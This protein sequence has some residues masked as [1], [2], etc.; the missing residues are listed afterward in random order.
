M[1]ITDTIK[2]VGVN[3]HKVDLFEGQYPVANGMAYNSY[4][5][6][7]EK[8]AVMDTVDANFTHEWLDKLEQVLDGR[9]PDYLIVQHME[10]DHAANVA[11]FLKVYPDTT[12]V[13]NVK[14]FQ[15][16]Y[17]FFG[18][19]LEGQKLEV[20]NGGTLSLGNHQLTFVFAPMVHWPEVMVTYDST[21]K[22][23]FSADG[24]G[25]FGALD[26]EE[27]WDDEARRYFIGI[28]GK[29][30]AQVQSLLKVAAT[31]DIQIICPLHG[32]VLSEDL[33]H[34]I[35]L[36]DTWSSYTP[37]EEGIVIAYTSVYGHTKK[38]VD[39]LADK[40]RSKGCPKVVVYDLARDDMSLALSDAFRYSKLILATTTY[41]ASIYPF[42]HDYI[43]RLV[44]HNFQ[45]RTVGLIENGSWAPLAAKVMREMMA[46][47]KKIN[48]LDT[49]VKIL[50]AI[51]QDNQYQ[52]EAMADE[53]CKEYIAQNDTL[54][55][56]NDLTALFR[57]GY[58]L[59]VVTSND[60]KKDNGLIVNTVIQLTDTPNRVAVNINK[61]NYSHHVIKQTGVLNVNCLS[62][63]APFSVFQQ[64][65]FQTGRSVDKFAGQTVHR[66]DN[67]LVFLDKYINAFMSLKVEDYVDL[68]THGMFICSVTEARVMSNQETMT[69]TY[70]QNNVKPKPE[71]EGKKGFV[72]KVCGYI[73]E[74][75]ELPADYICPLCKHGAADFEPI[76]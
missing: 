74:G 44:E 46:K 56:K 42:M 15:M 22:V 62:T 66:S 58:G 34:Y 5:I 8:I 33:G 76:E 37:E 14:T 54:A 39:L 45:N 28:V 7:D 53:L 3:D 25:K 75:D 57:I 23:L 63:E 6:L 47:C 55:N 18:L 36:Y 41:N 40:L 1:R 48:W 21:D 43:S 11:N 31:L 61:A 64:F 27:D 70:Y 13:A 49:T 72:C 59:Y 29:Y 38:A 10:P 35:G 20:T 60:G 30:G 32:P 9:K 69:Y 68:G 51:N 73:Y 71:T 67:G 19:T 16:I 17:N 12:V 52:L 4:V 65:G 2:Y 26:V 50:S 24:F